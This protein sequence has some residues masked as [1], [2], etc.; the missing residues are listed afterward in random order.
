MH[1]YMID[2]AETFHGCFTVFWCF[3]LSVRRLK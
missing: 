3:L 2:A 1:N